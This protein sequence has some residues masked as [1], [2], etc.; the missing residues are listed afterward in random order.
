M[1]ELII[2]M[3]NFGIKIKKNLNYVV[4]RK[5]F[6][7]FVVKLKMIYFIILKSNNVK[8]TAK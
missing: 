6:V 3:K 7:K 5:D 1:K 8:K 2:A 4:P